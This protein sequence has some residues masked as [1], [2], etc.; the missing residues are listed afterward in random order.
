MGLALRMKL[1]GGFGRVMVGR[2]CGGVN[3]VSTM[4]SV[5]DEGGLGWIGLE[6]RECIYA[7]MNEFAL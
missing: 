1:L 2:R 4:R 7:W 6:F 5:L 3:A